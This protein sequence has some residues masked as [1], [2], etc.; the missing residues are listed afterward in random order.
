[1]A[2]RHHA[3]H[4]LRWSATVNRGMRAIGIRPGEGRTVAFVAGLFAA[5]EVGR[6]F[7]EIGVDTLVVSQIG[8][9]SLPYLFIGLGA[10]GLITALAY[11]A[12]LGR[13]AADPVA[14]RAARRRRRDPA[15][16]ASC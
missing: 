15:R 3:A 12:A 8:P 6:G 11:G 14:R 1:M 13:V 9:G 10:I 7:G 4:D 5:L 2:A 16:R